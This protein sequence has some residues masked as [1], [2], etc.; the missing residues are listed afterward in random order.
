MKTRPKIDINESKAYGDMKTFLDRLSLGVV[1]AMLALSAILYPRLPDQIPTH[2]NIRGEIDGYGN[3]TWAAFLLPVIMTF[4]WLL[5][6]FIRFRGTSGSNGEPNP[7]ILA[8]VGFLTIA[9]LSL[10][11]VMSLVIA[12]DYRIDF[13]RV[14]MLSLF[15]FFGLIGSVMGRMKRNPWMGIRVPWTMESDRVWDATHKLG[16][17][18]FVGCGIAGVAMVLFN[19]P[20]TWLSMPV[21]VAVVVPILY[22]FVIRDRPGR[23]IPDDREPVSGV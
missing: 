11:H 8:F 6:R 9:F 14:M 21:A 23:E 18:I 1:V 15:V 4:L 19:V 13:T 7:T 17:W 2:W 20:M 5:F 22:S 10:I 16:G 12:L 3:K